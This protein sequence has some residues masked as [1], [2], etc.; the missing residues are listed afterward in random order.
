LDQIIF[1]L[2]AAGIRVFFM[3]W[4]D[5]LDAKKKIE[6]LVKKWSV[7]MDKMFQA[8]AIVMEAFE[9]MLKRQK[10]KPWEETK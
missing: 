4:G 9:R 1:A 6:D 10:E 7:V 8:P 2:L 3:L 5:K